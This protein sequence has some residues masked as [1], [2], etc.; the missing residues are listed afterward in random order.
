MEVS[1]AVVGATQDG[2]V[3]C[4]MSVIHSILEFTSYDL[5]TRPSVSNFIKKALGPSKSRLVIE[6][7]NENRRLTF[8]A[9]IDFGS[10]Q[11]S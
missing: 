3:L 2:D 7:M 6:T 5:R 11:I 8:Q 9:I 4:S 1:A 10:L